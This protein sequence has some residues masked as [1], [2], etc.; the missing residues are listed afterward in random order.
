VFLELVKNPGTGLP[1]RFVREADMT[2]EQKALIRDTGLV[3]VREQ[4]RDVSNRGWL[5]PHQVVKA[6]AAEV[7]F[8][9]NMAHFVKAWKAEQLRPEPGSPHPERTKEQYCR[10]DEPHRDYT[11]SPAYVDHL[12]RHLGTAEGFRDLLGM[13]PAPLQTGHAA[14]S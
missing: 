13:M 9:F 14:A 11:Y 1:I 12:V 10:Y 2:E 8:K 4:Q 3:I 5:K 7:P 6:V